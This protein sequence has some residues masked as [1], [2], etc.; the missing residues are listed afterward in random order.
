MPG[1]RQQ[2]RPCV[3]I[4]V[5]HRWQRQRTTWMPCG[6]TR[7]LIVRGPPH[8]GQSREGSSRARAVPGAVVDVM[9]SVV[10]MRASSALG[11]VLVDAPGG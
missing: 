11:G 6:T 5:P 3:V 1:R 9:W 8:D 10:L 2:S 4:D 7:P